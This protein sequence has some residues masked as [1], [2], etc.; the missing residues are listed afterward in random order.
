M[1]RDTFT[2]HD[3]KQISY[4]VW[5]DVVSPKAVVQIVH[6]MV[7]HIER[8]KDFAEYMNLNGF[9]VA[10]DDHR[11]HGLTDKDAFGLAGEGDLFEN[12]VSDLRQLTD[13]L[14]E[15][16]K[17]PLII[18]GHSYGSFLTQRYLTHDTSRIAGCILSGSAL[19]PV[20]T[21]RAGRSI[22]K[23]KMKKHKDEQGITFANMTF[24]KYDKKFRD[25]GINAWLTRDTEI[26]GK[27]NTDPLC[28]FICSN[29]FYYYFFNGLYNTIK[30]DNANI[31]KDLKLLIIAGEKD[32]VGS[33]GKLVK[34]L[35]EK[36]VRL[37]LSPEMKLYENARHEILNEINRDEVYED[38]LDFVTDCVK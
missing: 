30:S 27:Y 21:V 36:F 13:I 20:F 33:Y 19:M 10:G 38:V 12:T 8:Y 17:L 6:G 29:G 7:E 24:K 4:A 14:I 37:G 3:G 25:G 16:Y 18:L 22:A 31:R 11:A 15:K 32:G 2:A 28:G 9:I 5:D 34:K 26:V 35:Y 1:I 23:G